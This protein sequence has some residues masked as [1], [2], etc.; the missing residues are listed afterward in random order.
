MP[1]N[2]IQ[3]PLGWLCFAIF[4]TFF[5]IW[6]GWDLNSST[7]SSL[8]LV[9][10]WDPPF[11][12]SLP[13]YSSLSWSFF[14]CLKKLSQQHT[15]IL[16]KLFPWIFVNLSAQ[17][18]YI[19]G[20]LH[21]TSFGEGSEWKNWDPWKNWAGCFFLSSWWYQQLGWQPEEISFHF[22]STLSLEKWGFSTSWS[23]L[24][25]MQNKLY[26]SSFSFFSL[27]LDGIV[28]ICKELFLLKLLLWLFIGY[29]FGFESWDVIRTSF[30]SW[31]EWSKK[32]WGW[33]SWSWGQYL[34]EAIWYDYLVSVSIIR[35]N[36]F[37]WNS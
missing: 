20:I 15:T 26:R 2:W 30:W 7:P 8:D 5:L 6:K 32:Y 28:S 33:A 13:L 12:L 23:V 10:F 37:L 3:Q 17:L 18:W 9:S 4:S 14:E 31:A 24:W 25:L 35:Y 27:F 34:D 19:Y 36:F 29:N 1:L 21:G 11:L 16:L 22:S